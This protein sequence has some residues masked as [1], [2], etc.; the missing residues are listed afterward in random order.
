MS[1]EIPKVDFDK[2]KDLSI[3]VMSFDELLVNLHKSKNHDPFSV[4]RISFFLI[5]LI[6]KGKYSHNVDFKTYDL[7]EGDLLFIAKHQIH[8][9][10]PSIKHSEGYCIIFNN[11]FVKNDFVLI[12][13]LHLNRLFNYHIESPLLSGENLDENLVDIIHQLYVEHKS[14][15][16]AAK[17]EILQSL[18]YVLLLKAERG[19]QTRST[20]QDNNRWL[21]IFS[22]F[23]DLLESEYIKNRNSHNYAERLF[24]SYKTL[25]EIVKQYTGK[26]AKAFIDDFVAIEI[27]RYLVSTALSVKEISYKTGFE[28]PSNL[29]KFFKKHT[30]IT[31][32]KFRG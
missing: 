6:T 18:L 3:Q 5:L 24:I 22:K 1:K 12:E 2:S 4:H 8:G 14:H 25:N 13:N 7:Q 21:E 23:K 32:F 15:K 31:P 26:T 9:F 20:Q 11:S 16:I 29:I 10:R 27:K 28:D 19:K 30:G 17:V